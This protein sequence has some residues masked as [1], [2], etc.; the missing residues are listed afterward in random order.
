MS[1]EIFNRITVY[2]GICHGKPCIKG[3]RIFISIIIDWLASGSTFE[4]IL[5]A[6]PSLTREDVLACLSYATVSVRE[7]VVPVEV[8]E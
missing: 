4:E 7:R 2:P 5:N 6:Y 8:V 3:T 1:Q